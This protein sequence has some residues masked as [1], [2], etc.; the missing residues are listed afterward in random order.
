VDETVVF[1]Q[2]EK[3]H[4]YSIIDL[5]VSET[6]KQLIEQEL[7][8]EVSQEVKEWLT[9]KYYQPTYGARPMRR[10]VQKEIEDPLSEEILKG[11][12]KAGTKIRVVLEGDAPVFAAA[13]EDV[14][15]TVN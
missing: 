5:L 13:E 6:N 9:D 11:K 1:H 10:A 2:L 7:L 14:L 3:E 8:I 4:L 15:S 12:F